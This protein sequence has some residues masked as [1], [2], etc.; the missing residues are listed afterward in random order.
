MSGAAKSTALVVGCSAGIGLAIVRRLCDAGWDV[1]GF[2]RREAVV[3]HPSYRHVV[4]DV[5]SPDFRAQLAEEPTPDALIYC[6]GVGVELDPATFER[7]IEAF[8]IN[9]MGAVI[10]AAVMVPRMVANGRGHFLGISSQADQLIDPGAPSYAASKAG[11]SSYLEGLA[12]ACKPRGVAVTN[13]R[14]GFVDT[15][16][17]RGSSLRPFLITA[18]KA[19]ELVERCLHTR[20][21]RFTYPKRMAALLWLVR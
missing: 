2:A 6:A 15:E 9:L 16:M 11:L 5:R 8:E 1:T 7:E 3:E 12:R 19:A 14:F 21:V 17:S 13:V 18:E 4:A 20:P 10:T